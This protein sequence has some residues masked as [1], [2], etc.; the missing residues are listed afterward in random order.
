MDSALTERQKTIL[1]ATVTDFIETAEPVG[2]KSLIEAKG[3]SLSSATIRNDLS[4]LEDKGYLT[5][6]HTSSGRVP[7]DK[8]YR[9]YV[10]SLM[11]LQKLPPEQRQILNKQLAMI[12]NNVSDVLAQ[13]TD[14]VS[15]L[16]DYT[17]LVLTPDIWR[18][19][20]KVVHLVLLDLD[21]VL[22]V[23]LSSAGVNQEFVMSLEGLAQ[24]DL[25]RLSR[26]L[27]Q[28]LEGKAA[29]Q[30]TEDLFAELVSELPHFK[31]A[32]TQL[33]TEI[34]RLV[35]SHKSR[36]L[37]S[38]G[39]SKMLRL[40]EFKNVEVTQKVLETLE[41]S[42]VLCHLLDRYMNPSTS[43]KTL[44]GEETQVENLKECSLVFTPVMRDDEPVALVGV[45]G[46]KRMMYPVVVPMIDRIGRMVSH[47]LTLHEKGVG[48]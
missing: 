47:S 21:K 43:Q 14:V 20:L 23:L 4:E 18:E 31:I 37:M 30:L 42:K 15:S 48:S 13:L 17:T 19:T 25:D 32:L 7:T 38:K 8:G 6:V 2:S 11:T 10:D 33:G 26:L 9:M 45:L 3:F 36:K 34:K 12:G 35:Q 5:H 24:A 29:Y 46:P 27:T 39:T 40:P 1:E 22:V 44:I 16:M 28:K 41:E